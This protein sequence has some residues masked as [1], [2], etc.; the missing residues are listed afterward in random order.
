MDMNIKTI[1]IFIQVIRDGSFSKAARSL[2]MTQPTISQQISRLEQILEARLFERVGHN[3]VPTDAAREFYNFGNKLVESVDEFQGEFKTSRSQPKG[4]V[5]YAMPESCQWTPHYKKIMSQLTQYPEIE[6]EISILPNDKIAE[7]IID[8]T[9]DFGFVTGEKLTPELRFEKFSDEQYSL[10]GKS[11]DLFEAFVSKNESLRIISYPGWELFFTTWAKTNGVWSKFKNNMRKPTVKI[12]T[13]AGAIYALKEGAGVGVFPTH[14]LFEE[15]RSKELKEF[16]LKNEIASCPIF[17][18]K[19]IG[20][21]QTKRTEL[22]VDLL[23]K[24]KFDLV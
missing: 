12:G 14:C 20:S 23:K 4:L 22:I 18:A 7:G 24:A 8:G 17:L 2:K 19:K 11:T 9:F 6:F 13:L 10:V 5:R 1:R 15:L 16:K 21:K 3:I